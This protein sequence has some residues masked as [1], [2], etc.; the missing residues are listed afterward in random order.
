MRQPQP[1]RVWQLPC[2]AL[3][4]QSPYAGSS[5]LRH[6]AICIDQSPRGHSGRSSRTPVCYPAERCALLRLLPLAPPPPAITMAGLLTLRQCWR[7]RPRSAGFSMAAVTP[8]FARP[9]Q[10]T[11][12]PGQLCIIS[13]VLAP[14]GKL[15]L[16]TNTATLSDA[17]SISAQLHV[18]PQEMTI[19]ALRRER[20]LSCARKSFTIL[21]ERSACSEL[22]ASW[23]RMNGM[24]ASRPMPSHA[25]RYTEG[26][27]C[28]A[29]A[30][31]PPAS[32]T[33][34]AVP[35]R[36]VA[37]SGVMIQIQSRLARV[38]ILLACD[39]EPVRA[40]ARSRCTLGAR[41]VR[42]AERDAPRPPA[43]SGMHVLNLVHRQVMQ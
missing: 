1:R 36:I 27:L 18:R 4:R 30:A 25:F 14:T 28:T 33:S 34:S 17:I 26:F 35:H 31:H 40:R 9:S 20:T 12:R 19:G 8:D 38:L 23:I 21:N 7:D 39:R 6:V 24:S 3:H 41:S 29:A 5:N 2:R 13:A 37:S 10:T 43:A 11:T 15:W 42:A 16:V 22:S 32:S